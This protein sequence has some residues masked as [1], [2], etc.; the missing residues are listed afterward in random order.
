MREHVYSY[1]SN[2]MEWRKQ[3]KRFVSRKSKYCSSFRDDNEGP[4][5]KEIGINIANRSRSE[6]Q[7]KLA[8]A[9][10]KIIALLQF[11]I[12]LRLFVVVIV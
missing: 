12:G 1:S 4:F 8:E 10:R 6:L 7:R 2:G 9:T 5:V 11:R 3:V